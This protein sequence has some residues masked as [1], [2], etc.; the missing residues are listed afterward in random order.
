M[1]SMS[2][3]TCVRTLKDADIV[4]MLRPKRER[5]WGSHRI[6]QRIFRYFGLDVEKLRAAKPD[7][8]AYIPGP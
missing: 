8:L 2:P 3:A 7:A 1:A 5:I 4:M 6:D